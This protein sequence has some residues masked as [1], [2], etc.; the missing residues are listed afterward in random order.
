MVRVRRPLAALLTA[1]VLA[2]TAPAW[3]RV[4]AAPLRSQLARALSVPHVPP[5]RSAALAVDL[6]T[7]ETLYA[8]NAS[9]SLSPASN[10]KLA[11][12]FAALTTLGP[13]HRIPTE[14]LGEGVLLEGVWDGDLVLKGYGDPGLT[15][16]DLQGFAAQLRA[17]GIRRVSGRVV[18]DETYFD[19]RRTVAGW[20][21]FHYINEC[22]PLSALVVDRDRFHGYVSR[23]PALS[24]A[25]HFRDVLR[26]SGIAVAGGFTLGRAAEE[27]TVLA[28]TTS[29]PLWRIVRFMNRESDNFTAELLLK[30]LGATE[31]GKGTSAAGAAVVMRELQEASIPTAGV[32]IVDGSGL[33][34]LDRLTAAALVG[35]LKAAWADPAL[36]AA[37]PNSLAV[38]GINGT[39][40]DR[41]RRAP[42]RGQVQA[43]TGTTR[44]ASTLSGYVRKR[45]VFA[46]LQNGNPVSSWWARIAQDRFAQV[47]AAQ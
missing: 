33:S 15:T 12:A 38:A 37:L 28:E 25:A 1:C 27:A 43:K 41:M 2:P 46:V 24:S 21:S 3:A 40:E 36:H 39:L 35:I 16:K 13:L 30:Q 32:R 29:A 4:E 17:Q 42:A 44:E 10:E 45:Y 18:G 11:V 7:G 6:T 23:R 19:R 14:V 47:L 9:R 22:E 26:A 34:R 31:V 20:K 5:A 8:H